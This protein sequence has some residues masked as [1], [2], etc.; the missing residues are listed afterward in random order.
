MNSLLRGLAAGPQLILFVALTLTC[1]GFGTIVAMG[2]GSSVFNI[3]LEDLPLI[4]SQPEPAYA[5]ALIWMN[6]ITQLVGFA[7]P[8]VLFF[9]LFGGTSIHYLQLKNGGIFL[10]IAPVL[11]VTTAP[12]IDYRPLLTDFSFPKTH[13][14]NVHLNQRKSWLSK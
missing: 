5:H 9:I 7:M 11:I 4:L 1:V 6:N 2:T 3:P 14:S 10:L 13:G 12:L 8:V